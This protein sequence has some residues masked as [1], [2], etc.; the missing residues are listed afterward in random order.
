MIFAKRTH[1]ACSGSLDIR[2]NLTDDRLYQ[3]AA[4]QKLSVP[5][6]FDAIVD[7]AGKHAEDV[8]E[9]TPAGYLEEESVADRA[10]L[11]TLV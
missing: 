4:Y 5:E 2:L 7:G 10:D 9:Q 3:T 11:P 6:D 8:H 1:R